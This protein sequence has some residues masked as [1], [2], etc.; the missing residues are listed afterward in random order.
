MAAASPRVHVVLDEPIYEG[1]RR[2]ARREG[3]PLSLKVR[4]LVKDALE[5]EEDRLLSQL[6]DR[7]S[8]TFDKKNSRTHTQTWGLPKR[9][10]H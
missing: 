8:A 7:R 9:S 5:A 6:A 1:L 3:I 2:W 10:R 4:D